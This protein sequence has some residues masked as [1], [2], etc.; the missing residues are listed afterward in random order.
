MIN[1]LQEKLWVVFIVPVP[2]LPNEGDLAGMNCSC[3]FTRIAVTSTP[4]HFRF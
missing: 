2:N 3:T 1:A 4:L